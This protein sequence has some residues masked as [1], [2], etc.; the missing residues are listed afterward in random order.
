[1]RARVVQSVKLRGL[2]LNV[3]NFFHAISNVSFSIWSF[4]I[5]GDSMMYLPRS[6]AKSCLFVLASAVV[7]ASS[8]ILLVLLRII[9]YLSKPCSISFSHKSSGFSLTNLKSINTFST[10][11]VPI[12]LTFNLLAVLRALK[13]S[14]NAGKKV[15][16]CSYVFLVV[17]L[18]MSQERIS[19]GVFVEIKIAWV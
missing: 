15:K 11:N 19:Y 5:L 9:P 6:V 8:I 17:S 7:I 10:A 16:I 2:S 13:S 12:T 1:M 14:S 3:T 18:W 4:V